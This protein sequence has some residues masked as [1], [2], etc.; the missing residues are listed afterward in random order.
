MLNGAPIQAIN[1]DMNLEDFSDQFDSIW[2]SYNSLIG[3]GLTD[4]LA[5][6][7]PTNI[8]ELSDWALQRIHHA[9]SA[10]Y[11][12]A[13]ESARE[14]LE[15]Y[16]LPTFLDELG[17]VAY[18]IKLGLL[19]TRRG[20]FKGWTERAVGK[21][22]DAALVRLGYPLPR[23]SPKVGEL[24]CFVREREAPPILAHVASELLRVGRPIFTIAYV[25]TAD[26]FG[27]IAETCE[28]HLEAHWT[29]EQKEAMEEQRGLGANRALMA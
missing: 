5:E 3:D 24:V 23:S 28:L 6:G 13:L 1:H 17:G 11:D 8:N 15:K 19:R 9:R 20:K 10:R 2:D 18:H 12:G 25:S 14:V 27:A 21:A 29:P 26:G 16:R 7:A 22:C 4:L